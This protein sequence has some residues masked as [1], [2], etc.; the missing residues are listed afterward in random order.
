ML[1][2]E[3][4]YL[5]VNPA[6]VRILGCDSAEELVGRHPKDTSPPFQPNGE[7]SAKLAAQYITQCLQ[8]GSARFEWV[9]RTARGQD[10]P[11][12]VILTR[13][14]WGGRQIIQAAINDIS[15]RKKAESELLKAL[16]REKELGQLKSNF[17][18]MVSHEFRTP[19]GVIMSSAEILDSYLEQLDPQER[20]EQLQSIQKNTRRMATLMEEVLLLGMVEAGK[21]DFKP[22][23]AN[24]PAFCR[25]LID[26]LHSAT[27]RKCPVDFMTRSIPEEAFTDK[28]LLRHIFSNLLSNAVKY[29]P[30]GSPVCFE[31]EQVGTEAV[32]RIRDQG[33]GVPKEDLQWLFNAFY[34]GRNAGHVPGTG[35]GLTIVKRCVELHRGTIKVESMVNQGTTVTVS[36]PMFSSL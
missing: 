16:A 34:R 10:I 13:I 27:D 31:I 4:A 17:V 30:E 32:C 33:V 26:E 21:M 1:H 20:R 15:E 8:Q 29:S 12:E 18:S 35:L 19:L 36:L 28:R 14:E 25:H 23:P 9:G 3:H 2:D 7:P 22:A 5:E 6:A 24:L 11:L